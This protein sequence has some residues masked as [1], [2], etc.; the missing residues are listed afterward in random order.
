MA[1][2]RKSEQLK[3]LSGTG[4]K[5]R[6]RDEVQPPPVPV[7]TK[8]PTWLKGEGRKQWKKLFPV[9]TDLKLITEID[10]DTFA[11]YCQLHG[12]II[13]DYYK[14]SEA[15]PP[16]ELA[17]LRLY[18]GMFGLDPSSRAKL[19]PPRKPAAKKNKFSLLK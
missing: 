3:A 10:L 7:A 6:A 15:A 18:A 17:Q 11:H 19:A 5:D 2:P 9:L 8:P 4:R 12:H 16:T 13:T 1:R 14:K